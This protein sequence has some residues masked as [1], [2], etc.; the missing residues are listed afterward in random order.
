MVGKRCDNDVIVMSLWLLAT[1]IKKKQSFKAIWL[2]PDV[3]IRKSI[4]TKGNEW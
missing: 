4:K 1:Q 3:I 2:K